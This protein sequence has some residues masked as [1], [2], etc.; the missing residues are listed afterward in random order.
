MD[1]QE[2]QKA[3]YELPLTEIRY[4]TEIGSTND[5]ALNW[6]ESGIQGNSLVIADSQVKGRG[7]LNRKWITNP[8]SSLA[9][10]IILKPNKEE[11]ENLCL[12]APLGALA[13]NYVL[14]ESYNLLPMIKWPNDVLLGGRKM[15]GILA[16]ACWSGEFLKGIVIGIGV[17]V[18]PESIPPENQVLFPVT[19]LEA[20]TKTRIDRLIF[21]EHILRGFFDWRLKITSSK[22]LSYWQSRL[23][24]QN[25]PITVEQGDGTKMNGIQKGVA[26]DGSLEIELEG[27]KRERILIGDVRLRPR[28]AQ[29]EV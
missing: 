21:L 12:F 10:S 28:N 15:C 9:F 3:L 11:S 4:F 24:Y 22:F 7:R 8:N 16:E 2:I 17:N 14:E 26:P 13:V 1:L 27:G 19:Y 18:T 25:E 6:L 23:A 20:H 5:E 29:R